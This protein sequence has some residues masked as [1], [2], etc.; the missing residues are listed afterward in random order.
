MSTHHVPPV[1]VAHLKAKLAILY[2]MSPDIRS[3][4]ELGRR[5]AGVGEPKGISAKAIGHWIFGDETREAGD[6]PAARFERLVAIFQQRLPGHRSTAETRA[7][8]LSAS[9]Q[10]LVVAFL[11]QGPRAD[12]IS[13]MLAARPAA[14][15]LVPA[16][17]PGALSITTRRALVDSLDARLEFGVGQSFRLQI[18]AASDGWLTLLQWG[19][20]GC[21][22]VELDDD[23]IT[24]HPIAAE[25]LLPLRQ[26]YFKE[27]ETGPK[28]FLFMRSRVPLPPDILSR[29]VTSARAP[30]DLDGGTLERLAHL[31][32]QPEGIELTAL[33]VHFT[34]GIYGPQPGAA[35]E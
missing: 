2:S 35:G 1:H 6:V 17:K 25:T 14:V 22:G 33:D 3:D 19:R 20:G 21:H 34:E 8:L 27:S 30:A 16:R 7:L 10:D 18:E 29:L 23:M 4:A 24:L 26:P 28:R 15:R 32:S 5:F 11:S 12:W 31:A 13:L 9:S